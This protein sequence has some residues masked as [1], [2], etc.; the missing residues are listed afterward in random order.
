[1]TWKPSTYRPVLE[2]L[3]ARQVPCALHSGA[4]AVAPAPVSP[5]AQ[6]DA[7][8]DA[9]V[10][11]TTSD[12][13][14][15]LNSVPVLNSLLGARATLFLDF[16]GDFESSWGSARNIT[17]P[18]YDQDND[19]NS[20]SNG[21]VDSIRK[22]WAYVAED[23]APF[24]INVTTAAP[25]SFDN[26]RALRVAI[27]G[28]G[29]WIGSPGGIAFVHSFTNSLPNT[30]F[31]FSKNLN[32]GDPRQTADA[33]SH[34]SGHAFGLQH[35][36]LY[37][38]HH[39]VEEYYAGPGDGRAPLMG[40]SAGA[41]RGL[42]WKGT[43]STSYRG[44]QDDMA[45]IANTNGFRYRRDD[46]SNGRGGAFRLRSTSGQFSEPGIIAKTTD[47]D[48]FVFRTLAGSVTASAT[49]PDELN[50]LDAVLELQDRRGNVLASADPNG[51]FNASITASVARGTYYWVVKSHGSYG[52]VGQYTLSGQYLPTTPRGALVAPDGEHTARA[53]DK[54]AASTSRG[55]GTTPFL[56]PG[57][58]N[59]L[60]PLKTLPATSL[61]TFAPPTWP[62]PTVSVDLGA[63]MSVTSSQSLSATSS[64]V[65]IFSVLESPWE[66]FN[67]RGP[68]A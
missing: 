45:I 63:D 7:G 64:R 58:T 9:V 56:L 10:S 18:P 1:M 42:W 11:S 54:P 27:G 48:F 37:D 41:T 35:Q 39:K 22:I 57:L 66:V 68:F 47:K 33:V 15:E 46:Y 65:A 3:E 14:R 53:L 55:L 30:V 25:L 61:P 67:D 24:K 32:N 17:I 49:V 12:S 8:S 21:E 31:V 43:P 6:P 23:F 5:P 19:P 44:R 34:E 60:V 20:L 16:N 36:S 29:D 13:G 51:S 28:T 62:V 59:A 4:V 2:V 40:S 38:G 26:R 52:D 50:N